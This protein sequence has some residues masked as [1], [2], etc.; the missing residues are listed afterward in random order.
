MFVVENTELTEC[1]L[2]GASGSVVLH[3]KANEF[4]LYH[5]LQCDGQFWFPRFCPSPSWYEQ[6]ELYLY[7]DYYAHKLE[8]GHKQFLRVMPRTGGRLLDIGCGTGVFIFSAQKRGYDVYGV[9]FNKRAIEIA[10]KRYRLSN[11]Y[12]ISWDEFTLHCK[13]KFDVVTFFE[14][15]EHL[16]NPMLFLEQ[17]K[18]V[19]KV[20]GIIA[21]T[22]PDRERLW[23]DWDVYDYPPHHFTRWNVV[24]LTKLLHHCGYQI[25][26]LKREPLTPYV[27]ALQLGTRIRLGIG[28]KLIKH[29]QWQTALSSQKAIIRRAIMLYRI[30]YISL[31]ILGL[32][33]LPFV[34]LY[35]KGGNHLFAMAVWNGE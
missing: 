1:H 29:A 23:V 13:E 7:R 22:V 2:C 17:I 8:W 16:E 24:S 34:T 30:K 14:F 35:G 32:P 11:V 3:V 25:I 33:L 31:S 6:Q 18:T 28:R 26:H 4:T 27:F 15:L 12:S 21:L 20:G 9:D 10:R 5:C 19:L